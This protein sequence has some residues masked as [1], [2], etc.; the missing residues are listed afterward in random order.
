[1]TISIESVNGIGPG[2]AKTLA[3]HRIANAEQLAA[4]SV[5][6]LTAIPGFGVVRARQVIAAAQE[7]LSASTTE[8]S[9]TDQ[10]VEAEQAG[11]DESKEKKK[12]SKK[13]EKKPGKGKK[14]KKGKK[15]SGKKSGK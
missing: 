3:D 12:K 15:K 6:E 8:T 11:D 7:A 2:A 4:T 10:P 1:M 14:G 5:S 9:A 13:K